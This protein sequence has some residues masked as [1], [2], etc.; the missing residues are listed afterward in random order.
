[1]VEHG[2]LSKRI[3]I[4]IPT[5]NE[6]AVIGSA[7]AQFQDLP[8]D[9]E[10]IVADSG[11]TDATLEIA[12]SFGATIVDGPPGRGASMNAGAAV[13]TGEI[14]LFLHADTRLPKTAHSLICRA[15]DDPSVAVTAFHLAMDGRGWR[16]RFIEIASKFRIR[17]QRTFFGDQAIAVRRHDFE[18]VGGYSE[19]ALMEDVALSHRLRGEGKLRTLPA[20]VITS[21]RRF[22]HGGFIRTVIF[23]SGL[24]LAYALGVPTRRLARLYRH[25]R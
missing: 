18:R 4:V 14:L 5:L 3:S 15:F 12:R 2:N 11:S 21:A 9:W 24:Q 1:M 20:E 23:M 13:A 19:P 8:G 6:A 16:Y 25:A 22:E 10:I 7:L 17:I